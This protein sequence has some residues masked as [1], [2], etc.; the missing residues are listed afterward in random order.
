MTKELNKRPRY[1]RWYKVT[2]P[3]CVSGDG[4]GYHFYISKGHSRNLLIFFAGGGVVWNSFTAAHPTDAAGVLAGDP[5]FYWANLRPVTEFMNINQG[6]TENRSPLNYFYDWNMAV[7]TYSTGDF[8][9]GRSSLHYDENDPEK[10]MYF[11]GFNNY[12]AA[13]EEIKRIFPEPVNLLIAGDSAG[14]FGAAALA[15]DIMKR[16]DPERSRVTLISD[17][18]TLPWDRWKEVMKDLWDTVPE[19]YGKIESDNPVADWLKS[20]SKTYGTGVRILYAC[21][22]KDEVL[23]S[24]WNSIRGNDYGADPGIREEFRNVLREMVYDLMDTVPGISFFINDYRFVPDMPGG[25]IQTGTI[26]TCIRNPL[27]F[28]GKTDGIN[29]HEWL[30]DMVNGESYSVGI[31]NL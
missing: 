5:G 17:S 14:G 28:T 31:N 30:K 27:F 29:M 23:A 11:N 9:I 24:Y 22:A 6:I 26:H 25:I 8:H 13:I 1:N 2:L 4:S 18:S 15:E 19:I 21:S 7:I 16:Y 3:D 20:V 12:T 10:V